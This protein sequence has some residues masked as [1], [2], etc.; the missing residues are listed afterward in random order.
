MLQR[1]QKFFSMDMGTFLKTED[2]LRPCLNQ[3]D[4]PPLREL[5]HITREYILDG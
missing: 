1:Y 2:E 3:I 5:S 4:P